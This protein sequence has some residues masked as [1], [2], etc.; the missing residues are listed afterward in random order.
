MVTKASHHAVYLVGPPCAQARPS[1]YPPSPSDGEILSIFPSLNQTVAPDC[2]ALSHCPETLNR[3]HAYDKA[4]SVC[5]PKRFGRTGG[6]PVAWTPAGL[7]LA[8]V[9]W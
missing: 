4:P 8:C 3:M 9:V 7:F 5:L 1:A 6:F 2:R